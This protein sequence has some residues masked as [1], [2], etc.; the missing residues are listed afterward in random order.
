MKLTCPACG[1]SGALEFFLMDA[2]ARE[3]VRAAFQL[4][5]PLGRQVMT[6]IGLFRPMQRALTWDRV[7]KLLAELLEP[8]QAASV[9]RNGIAHPA[10]ID[11]WKE[12]LDQVLVNRAKLNLPLKSHGYLFEIVANLSGKQA[13]AQERQREV[14]AQRGD[15]RTAG[16]GPKP[17]IDMAQQAVKYRHGVEAA[18]AALNGGNPTPPGEE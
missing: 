6:Y 11:Y 1:A 15:G 14:A 16:K 2:S 3:S 12:A 13:G 9:T 7:E 17:A 5:A 10:P 18:R 4:P 8:I